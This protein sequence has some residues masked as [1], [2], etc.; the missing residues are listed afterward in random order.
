M[1]SHRKHFSSSNLKDP[2]CVNICV[3]FTFEEIVF[4][5]RNIPSRKLIKTLDYVRKMYV[6]YLF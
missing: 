2:L 6:S 1:K 3:Y 5:Q 4:L